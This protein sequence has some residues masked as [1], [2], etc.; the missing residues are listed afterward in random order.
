MDRV[1]CSN[2]TGAQRQSL[3]RLTKPQV[4]S[5]PGAFFL[6]N[7]AA[8]GYSEDLTHTL[9][10]EISLRGGP[11]GVINAVRVNVKYYFT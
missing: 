7:H 8:E 1:W 11:A 4:A 6:C 10:R 2:G 5:G 3:V 9:G